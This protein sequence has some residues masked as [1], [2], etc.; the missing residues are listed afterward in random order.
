MNK[1]DEDDDEMK[2]K[3]KME[4]EYDENKNNNNANSTHDD[5]LPNWMDLAREDHRW[6]LLEEGYVR[7]A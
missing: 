2:M 3:M 7:R 6:H 4:D 5:L 1:M